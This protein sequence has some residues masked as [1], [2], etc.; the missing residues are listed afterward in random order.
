MGFPSAKRRPVCKPVDTEDRRNAQLSDDV[1][2]L[3][4][5][6]EETAGAGDRRG[7]GLL[8]PQTRLTRLHSRKYLQ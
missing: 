1:D 7:V 5:L 8:S 3:D 4:G 6:R 2:D